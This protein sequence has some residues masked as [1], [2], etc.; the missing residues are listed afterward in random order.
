MNFIWNPRATSTYRPPNGLTFEAA[1]DA[2]FAW[3][4]AAFAAGWEFHPTYQSE[5]VDTAFSMS[6]KGWKVMATCRPKGEKQSFHSASFSVWGP[7]TLH[8]RIDPM[9]PFD[10]AAI[11]QLARTCEFCGKVVEQTERVAFCN[12]SCAA[13]APEA[14]K[15]LERPGWCE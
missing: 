5:S 12:R 3:R 4:D 13:C 8:V 2:I 10:L 15:R 1:R 14:R 7:D 6:W 11:E 9:T